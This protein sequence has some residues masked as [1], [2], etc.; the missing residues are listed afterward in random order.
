MMGQGSGGGA[1]A[2]IPYYAWEKTELVVTEESYT[3][4]SEPDEGAGLPVG[5]GQA[6]AGIL[7]GLEVGE[8]WM[9]EENSVEMAE[10][11]E[12]KTVN[13]TAGKQKRQF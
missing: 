10:A 2:I 12:N 9:A 6:Q 4:A 1:L 5:V 7:A 13:Q 11:E 8:Q 3:R